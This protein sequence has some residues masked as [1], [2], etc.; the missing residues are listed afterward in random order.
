MCV[1]AATGHTVSEDQRLTKQLIISAHSFP[2]AAEF[3]AKPRNLPF[4]AE[5]QHYGG[6]W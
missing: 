2:W 6:I 5:F 4:A 3:W 1:S